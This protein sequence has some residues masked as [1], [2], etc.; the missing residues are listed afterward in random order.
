M[1]APCPWGR[2][3]VEY[4]AAR[5]E[6]SVRAMMVRCTLPIILLKV[7]NTDKGSYKQSL[8]TARVT[9]CQLLVGMGD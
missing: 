5:D 2:F 3:H 7:S 6:Q 1:T 4:E 9:L 8:E